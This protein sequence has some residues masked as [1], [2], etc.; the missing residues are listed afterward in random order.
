MADEKSI[1]K[2]NKM[3]HKKTGASFLV[4]YVIYVSLVYTDSKNTPLSALRS[5]ADKKFR[6]VVSQCAYNLIQS[7]TTYCSAHIYIKCFAHCSFSAH[8]K[9]FSK[10]SKLDG[11]DEHGTS[12][13]VQEKEAD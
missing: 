9:R 12:R 3:I 5:I 6:R 13:V 2:M 11:D 10:A 7:Y 1:G 4:V 8:C